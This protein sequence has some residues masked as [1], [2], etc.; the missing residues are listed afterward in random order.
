VKIIHATRR[1]RAEYCARFG[2]DHRKLV[3]ARG[4]ETRKQRQRRLASQWGVRSTAAMIAVARRMLL[5][6]GVIP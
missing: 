1:E 5:D 3:R 4:R 6:D 2:D